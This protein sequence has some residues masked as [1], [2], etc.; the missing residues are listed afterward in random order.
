MS[1]ASDRLLEYKPDGRD[2]SFKAMTSSHVTIDIEAQVGSFGTS[3]S[4]GVESNCGWPNGNPSL[5]PDVKRWTA[6]V[7]FEA[8]PGDGLAFVTTRIAAGDHGAKLAVATGPDVR[9][10]RRI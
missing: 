7:S 1:R 9:H 8:G 3:W 5:P 2:R 4:S 6:E 10:W